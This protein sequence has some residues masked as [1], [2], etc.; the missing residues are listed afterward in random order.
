MPISLPFLPPW[1]CMYISV[2]TQRNTYKLW[3]NILQKK[4]LRFIST[5]PLSTISVC[6]YAL[7]EY[8][9]VLS[10]L[11]HV[12]LFV[13]PCTTACQAA[14][15]VRFSWQEYWSKLPYPPPGESSQPRDQTHIS[16][17]SCTAG[18]FFTTEPRRIG[19]LYAIM[20]SI[21]FNILYL[22]FP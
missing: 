8:C 12:W 19:F 11:T 3:S 7:N 1:L 16:C 15:S 6:L 20:Y 18:R 10:C 21:K 22:F 17:V 13:T 14:L 5:T 2:Y 9:A 4:E